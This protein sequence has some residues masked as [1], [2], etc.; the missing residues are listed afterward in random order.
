MKL[1]V[2]GSLK[3]GFALDFLL[4]NSEFLCSAKMKGFSLYSFGAYPGVKFTDSQQALFGELYEVS[5]LT[6]SKLDEVENGYRR[7]LHMTTE[8]ELVSIYVWKGVVPSW[9]LPI[10]SGNWESPLKSPTSVV[11][12]T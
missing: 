8:G 9:A 12:N 7:E 1:F 11:T 10:P 4:D 5:P 2:Y 3:K 6:I